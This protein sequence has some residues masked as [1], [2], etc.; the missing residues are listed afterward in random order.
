MS[1]GANQVVRT[2]AGAVRGVAADGPVNGPADGPA[3][4][5]ASGVTAFRGIP[6]AQPPVGPLRFAA[7]VPARPWEGVR[8]AHE[9]GSPPPQSAL[10]RGMPSLWNPEHGQDCLT[11]NVFTPEPGADAGLPVL[12]W[13][14]GGAWRHGAASEPLYDATRLAAAGAVIVTF[15][16]RVGFEGF[17]SLAGAPDNRGY[18]DQLAALRWVA[19]NITGFGGDPG[20]VT[21]FG[22]SA[23]ASAVISLTAASAGRGLFRRAIAQ[24]AA[25]GYQSPEHARRI[26]EAIAAELGVPATATAMVDVPP[27]AILKV[28][29]ALLGSQVTTLVPVIDGELITGPPSVALRDGVGRDTDLIVGFT[30]DEYRLF[31]LSRDLSGVDVEA[32]ASELGLDAGAVDAYRAGHPGITDADLYT[33]MMSDSVFRIPSLRAAQAHAKSGGATYAYEFT[34]RSPALRGS[35]GACH[36]M[37]LPFVFGNS[38]GFARMLLGEPPTADFEPLS[39]LIRASWLSFARTGDPGWPRFRPGEEL[40]RIWNLPPTVVAS[41]EALSSRIWAS[42]KPQ[43]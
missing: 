33:L 36:A 13:I 40:A 42:R 24:S 39:E 15:N 1:Q 9:F 43:G 37:D 26:A 20:N 8:D 11:V 18:L 19:D 17:A 4:G 16:Y 5:V 21:V 29:D 38:G 10:M 25:D 3:T 6:Y 28:Q 27:E 14:Y 7:P 12:V 35:L 2:R 32:T 30:A 31:T 23:G 41:P 22:E 34:W